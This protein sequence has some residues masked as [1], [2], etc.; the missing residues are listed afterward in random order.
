[1]HDCIE[2]Q[3]GEVAARYLASLSVRL[4]NRRNGV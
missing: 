3:F 4:S 1:M 2:R